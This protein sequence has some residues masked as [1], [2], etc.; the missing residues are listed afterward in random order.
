MNS[1]HPAAGYS[2]AGKS[3]TQEQQEMN[4]KFQ[5]TENADGKNLKDHIDSKVGVSGMYWYKSFDKI[6]LLGQKLSGILNPKSLFQDA[7]DE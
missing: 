4:L 3:P 5:S 1:V 6:P 2:A 7:V